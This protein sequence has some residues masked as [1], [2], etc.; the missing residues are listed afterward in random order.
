MDFEGVAE[1]IAEGSGTGSVMPGAYELAE[2]LQY[3]YLLLLVPFVFYAFGWAFH[4]ILDMKSKTKFIY[5]SLLIAVTFFV[6]F[7]LALIIHNNTESAKELMGLETVHFSQSSTFYIILFLGFLVYIIWSILIHALSLE[8]DKRQISRNIKK[9]ITHLNKDI[10]VLSKKLKD[11]DG[12]ARKINDYRDDVAVVMYGNL[13]KYVDQFTSG[14]VS[15]LSPANMKEV[16]E[17]C[18]TLKKD[19]EDKNDIR[20]GVVRVVNRR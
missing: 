18:L 9:M 11:T 17:R 3:N 6:D 2:A 1:S 8:W 4:I 10:E 15:Y 5:I 19:F 14:W 20:K 13:K 16:K 7:L 12:L